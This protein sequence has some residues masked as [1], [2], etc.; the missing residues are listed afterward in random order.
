MGGNMAAP[1]G[2]AALRENVRSRST[3]EARFVPTDPMEQHIHAMLLALA[4]KRRDLARADGGGSPIAEQGGSHCSCCGAGVGSCKC[5][6][7]SHPSPLKRGRYSNESF[8]AHG[9]EAPPVNDT[10]QGAPP[11]HRLAN[12]EE[13]ELIAL[14]VLC[15]SV[16]E[17]GGGCSPPQGS[18]MASKKR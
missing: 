15:G 2:R 4:E 3:R 7:G 16:R 11:A 6:Y 1:G 9:N 10:Q 17:A 8:S 13:K 12:L 18:G 5:E 14:Q